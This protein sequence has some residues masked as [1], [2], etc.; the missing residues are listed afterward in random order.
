MNFED[1]APELQEKAKACKSPEELLALAHQEGYE[2]SDAELEQVS[3]GG[4]WDV[5]E[6]DFDSSGNPLCVWFG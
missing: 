4:F 5:D 2:L 6:E 1:L 3:G